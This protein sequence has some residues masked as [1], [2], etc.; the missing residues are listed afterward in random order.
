M[1][2]Y[3]YTMKN[4]YTCAHTYL[5]LGVSTGMRWH[6]QVCME[7]EKERESTCKKNRTR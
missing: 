6:A 7:M 1:R 4:A 5:H 3:T 2:V